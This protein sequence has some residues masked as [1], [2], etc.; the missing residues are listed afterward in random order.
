MNH[1]QIFLLFLFCITTIFFNKLHGLEENFIVMDAS[2]QKTISE[3]GPGIDERVSPC[4]S[5][6]ITLSLIGFD[7][8]VLQDESNPTWNYQ[9]GYD[10]FLET[11]KGP[12]SPQSWMTYSCVWYSKVLA[13]KIG[14]EKL[15][16]YL[17]AL[18][19]GN[20]DLSGGLAAPGPLDPAWINSSLKI[21]P[22][23][24]V[25]YLS[26]VLNGNTSLST[27]A[28]QM[29]K[30]LLFKEELTNGWLLFGKTGWSGTT[31][32]QDGKPLQLGWFVGW[33]EKK[34]QMFPFAYLIKDTQIK[35]DQRI[36]RTKELLHQLD[37]LG[38][39]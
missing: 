16:E 11:W 2:T 13:I 7:Y 20:N 6:K 27:H 4:S 22:R 36:P 25:V 29:S 10:D 24:Q 3:Q 30:K 19:Y 34:G 32:G 28:I 37:L 26:N 17:I 12:L 21:S 35:L 5:F 15:Q 38:P 31:I 8:G 14:Q 9:E 1:K 33:I 18:D 23:E 39:K